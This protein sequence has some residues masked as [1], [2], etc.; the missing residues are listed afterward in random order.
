MQP[1]E[2]AGSG[3]MRCPST[4]DALLRAARGVGERAAD[5]T[6]RHLRTAVKRAICSLAIGELIYLAQP[7]PTTATRGAGR[8]LIVVSVAALS[9][10]VTRS[11][12]SLLLHRRPSMAREQTLAPLQDLSQLRVRS[13]PDCSGELPSHLEDLEEVRPIARGDNFT[14]RLVASSASGGA[15]RLFALKTVGN[16]RASFENHDTRAFLARETELLFKCSHCSIVKALRVLS[17]PGDEHAVLMEWVPCGDFFSLLQRE[18]HLEERNAR[19]YAN[20]VVSALEHLHARQIAHRDL[21]PENLLLDANGHLKLSGLGCGKIILDR[22]YTIV[23]SLPYVAPEVLLNE[24][25]GLAVDWWAFGVL[26]FEITTGEPPFADF[27]EE[28]TYYTCGQ[29]VS[30]DVLCPSTMSDRLQDM[31]GRLLDKLPQSRL[32]SGPEGAGA[33]RQHPWFSDASSSAVRLSS[34]PSLSSPLAT[35]DGPH[36]PPSTRSA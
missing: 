16:D 8:G 13:H 7:I 28:L 29:I 26:L 18:G 6:A 34:L 17:G 9:A 1:G 20:E 27:G 2:E 30:G 14:V 23:G 35:H 5:L 19:F 33:V 3:E 24:G 11:I 32:G 36:G 25:H 15:R 12:F 22:S 21:K 31:V 4:L 10:A